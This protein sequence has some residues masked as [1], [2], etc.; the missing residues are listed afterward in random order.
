M[1]TIGRILKSQGNQGGLKL[2]LYSDQQIKPFFQ[3]IYL[4]SNRSTKEFEVESLKPHKDFFTLKLKTVDSLV[5]ARELAGFDV[6]VPE[7]WLK[8]LAKG[9]YYIYQLLDC[10]VYTKEKTLVGIIKDFMF[11]ENNDLLIVRN[12]D[13]EMLIPFNRSICLSLD[14]K[15]KELIINPPEGLL[16]LNEI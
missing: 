4:H 5:K 16:E 9:D 12:R 13:R 14:L 2:K 7:E 11:V 15:K 3:K 8:P 10:S 1:V 6:K